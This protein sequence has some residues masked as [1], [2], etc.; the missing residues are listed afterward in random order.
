MKI[1]RF[2]IIFFFLQTVFFGKSFFVIPQKSDNDSKLSASVIINDSFQIKALTDSCWKYRSND[3]QKALRFGL[4]ALKMTEETGV[5]KYKSRILSFIGVVY[6]N[7][8]D[9]DKALVYYYKSLNVSKQYKDSIQ[10]GYSY[11]NLSDYYYKKASYSVSL[12]NGLT[13]YEI[14]SKINNDA[15]KAYSLNNLGEI[16]L[17]QKNYEKALSFFE[18][19]AE[20]RKKNNDR[21]GFAKSLIGLAEVYAETGK[22]KKAE[23]TYNRS[24]S[25]SKK[26]N[27]KKG[28]GSALAGLSEIYFNRGDFAR[29][30]ALADS[31]LTID[32]AIKNKY[33]IIKNF[34]RLGLINFKMSDFDLAK[35]YFIKAGKSAKSSGHLDQ[36]MESYKNLG[37]LFSSKSNYKLAYYYYKKYM[38]LKDSIYSREKMGK[39]ADL[40]TTFAVAKKELENSILKKDVEYQKTLGKLFVLISFITII[41]I[42]LFVMKNRANRKANHLLT[43]LNNSKDKFFSIIAHD[44]KNPFMGLLGYT[45]LLYKNYDSLS[46][47]DIKEAVKSMYN[48]SRNLFD[49]LEGLLEWSRAQTGRMEYNPS[50]FKLIEESTNV[51]E[52]FIGNATEKRITLVNDIPQSLLLY[53]DRKMVNTILRNLVA[54]GIKFTKPGGSVK[55]C[56]EETEKEVTVCVEDTGIGMSEEEL[57]SLFRIDIHHTTLGT[58]NEAGTGVGLILCRELVKI[59][60]GRIWAESE[61][62]KG[63]KFKFTLPKKKV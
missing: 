2:V 40:Q 13:A 43:E 59:N 58:E 5:N 53:A 60:R 50:L 8:G 38:S 10:L 36:E 11:E 39:I 42:I 24:L 20:L 9:L 21:R 19:A 44:L 16:Y 33:G 18:Q 12:E 25:I 61:I 54:N 28:I 14:F 46:E 7:I 37:V 34:N 51:V 27:Y 22:A 6:R 32:K 41:I 30:L 29:A 26:I 1:R 56:A 57:G 4:E 49:L 62:N 48:M 55:I 17:K 63:S 45:E 3:P 23:N 31:S 47:E 35:D 52:L 15:G